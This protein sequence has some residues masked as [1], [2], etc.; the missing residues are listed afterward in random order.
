MASELS[1]VLQNII[2]KFLKN[3]KAPEEVIDCLTDFSKAIQ[4]TDTFDVT[5]IRPDMTR[6]FIKGTKF[7]DLDKENSLRDYLECLK[8]SEI[9]LSPMN[10]DPK[11]IS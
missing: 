2:L 10:T 5:F 8:E 4:F 6:C 9:Q 11:C 1:F 3:Q 7:C